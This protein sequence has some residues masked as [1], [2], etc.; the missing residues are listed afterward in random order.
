M[1]EWPPEDE[2]SLAWLELAGAGTAAGLSLGLPHQKQ[3]WNRKPQLFSVMCWVYG[4]IQELLIKMYFKWQV[5]GDDEYQ[6]AALSHIITYSLLALYLQSLNLTLAFPTHLCEEIVIWFQG[7]WLQ[8]FLPILYR[9]KKCA[10]WWH[11]PIS[12]C[13]ADRSFPF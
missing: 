10:K 8:Y 9:N 5:A 4:Q 12:F 1:F 11:L 7:L 3:Q 13:K 6:Q 2:V